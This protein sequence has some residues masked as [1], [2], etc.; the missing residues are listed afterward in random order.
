MV[1]L[2]T[3]LL[4][5]RRRRERFSEAHSKPTSTSSLFCK[6]ASL[7]NFCTC[8]VGTKWRSAGRD[9]GAHASPV[10]EKRSW[11]AV[12][13]GEGARHAMLALVDS[14]GCLYLCADLTGGRLLEHVGCRLLRKENDAATCGK[15]S[16]HQ[17]VSISFTCGSPP[18]GYQS[19]RAPA[20]CGAAH[21]NPA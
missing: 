21:G 14:A 6:P 1:A 17:P 10:L 5:V 3:H 13:S 8:G 19:G 15:S 4:D 7:R 11:A 2:A 18:Q 9:R 12:C 20:S 16:I